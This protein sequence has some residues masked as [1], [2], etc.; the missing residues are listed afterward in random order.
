MEHEPVNSRMIRIRLE[1][2]PR[3]VS[4]ISILKRLLIS[5]KKLK[6]FMKKLKSTSRKIQNIDFPIIQGDWNEEAGSENDNSRGKKLGVNRWKEL[7]LRIMDA[8]GCLLTEGI[9]IKEGW[10]D[11]LWQLYNHPIGT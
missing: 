11:Y 7:P 8:N 1:T 3:N 6:Q 2:F 5:T 9:N 4:I 10:T